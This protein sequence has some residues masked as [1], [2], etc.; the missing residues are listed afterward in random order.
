MKRTLVE[1]ESW[2]VCESDDDAWSGVDGMEVYAEHTHGC[3]E[4]TDP[5]LPAWGWEF[6]DELEGGIDV[7]WKCKCAVPEEVVG[8]VQLHNWGRKRR[9]ADQ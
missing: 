3:R 9:G 6:D 7:C 1:F 4:D 8:L 5:N 2:S